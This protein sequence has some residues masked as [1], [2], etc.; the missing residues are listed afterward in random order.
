MPAALRLATQKGW[1]ELEAR[2]NKYGMTAVLYACY[3]G[4]VECLP[5]LVDGL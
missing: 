2:D 1:G 4:D 3:K 5:L